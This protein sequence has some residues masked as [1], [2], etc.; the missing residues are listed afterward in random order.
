MNKTPIKIATIS[1]SN[2]GGGGIAAFRLHQGL[3]DVVGVMSN[4]FNQITATDETAQIIKVEPENKIGIKKIIGKANNKISLNELAVYNNKLSKLTLNCEIASLPY[5]SYK[6]ENH[7]LIKE[8]DIVHLHWVADFVNYPS[9][10]KKIKKPI[11]W[12]LHDMNPFQ[13][14]FHYKNDEINNTVASVLDRKVYQDKRK[15]IHQHSNLHIVCLTDWMFKASSN[16][17]IL[18]DYPH[19]LIP[20]GLDF[21]ANKKNDNSQRLKTKYNIDNNNKTLL[22]VSQNLKN[23][24]KGFDLLQKALNNISDQ[25]FNII[26]LGNNSIQ[27]PSNFNHVHINHIDDLNELNSIYSLADLFLLPSKEDNLPNVMLEAFANGIPIIAFNTGG[28]KDWIISNE[29]G[30]LVDDFSAKEFAKELIKFAQNTYAFNSVDI[31]RYAEKHFNVI[32]QRKK[33]IHLYQSILNKL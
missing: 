16:S 32:N 17:D 12:T 11:V 9:F 31:K 7:P 5:S 6:I 21:S 8:A 25:C 3:N 22:C 26:T 13:G 23:P 24:R 15:F 10:F 19:Y 1:T 28:M 30:I 18:G 33:Y 4:F 20:N 29:N 27:L 2:K 14:L